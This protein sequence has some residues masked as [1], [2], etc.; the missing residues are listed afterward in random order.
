M[1]LRRRRTPGRAHRQA[2]SRSRTRAQAP[3]RAAPPSPWRTRRCR[4]ACPWRARPRSASSAFCVLRDHRPPVA[5]GR[6]A[7]CGSFPSRLLSLASSAG[8]DEQRPDRTTRRGEQRRP[9]C[10]APAGCRA[11]NRASCRSSRGRRAPR[12]SASRRPGSARATRLQRLPL[13]GRPIG[14]D[15]DPEPGVLAAPATPSPVPVAPPPELEDE[16]PQPAASEPAPASKRREQCAHRSHRRS[17]FGRR[18]ASHELCDELVQPGPLEHRADALGDRH[19]DAEPRATRRAAPAPSSALD[20]HADLGD[21]PARPSRRGRSARPR[22]GCG[23]TATSTSRS[24][25]PCPARPANVSGRPPAD[26]ASRPI[27]ARP[28]VTSAAFAVVAEARGRPHHRRRARSR[29]WPPRRAR[30]RSTSSLT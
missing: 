3:R 28:R 19:L 30:P 7:A 26:S 6:H 10:R 4:Q 20:D 21:A 13:A 15:G 16:P 9:P 12:R 8:L 18:L 17:L 24:G 14:V 25:R 27:S 23:P 1:L 2:L 29:S 22:D 11:R 5:L